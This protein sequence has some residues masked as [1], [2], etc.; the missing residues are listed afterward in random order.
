MRD[1]CVDVEVVDD[2]VELSEG[3]VRRSCCGFCCA[4]RGS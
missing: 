4:R 1:E 3:G 2:D